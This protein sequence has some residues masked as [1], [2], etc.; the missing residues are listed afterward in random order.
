MMPENISHHFTEY[1]EHLIAQK[2]KNVLQNMDDDKEPEVLS[3]QL[4]SV[5][6]WRLIYRY[7]TIL[8][9]AGVSLPK[10]LMENPYN[11]FRV[12]RR[13]EGKRRL[14]WGYGVMS[15]GRGPRWVMSWEYAGSLAQPTREDVVHGDLGSLKKRFVC[16]ASRLGGLRGQVLRKTRSRDSPPRSIWRRCF[17][18]QSEQRNH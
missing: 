6:S 12:D 14:T 13:S 11:G 10:R 1:V 8:A 5:F 16:R 17:P 3:K 4:S 7:H 18:N 15:P 2:S 9:E